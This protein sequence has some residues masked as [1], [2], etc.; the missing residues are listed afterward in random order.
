MASTLSP[1]RSLLALL[2]GQIEG[3][4]EKVLAPEAKR[5]LMSYERHL[6][7]LELDRKGDHMAAGLLL[8]AAEIASYIPSG[9]LGRGSMELT[10]LEERIERVLSAVHRLE[11]R[12]GRPKK[13][14]GVWQGGRMKPPTRPRDPEPRVEED[15]S[16]HSGDAAGGSDGE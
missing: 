2:R 11:R 15:D 6:E 5:C 13:K 10:R 14:P 12:A 1:G 4:D 9:K 16:I 8:N 3:V 7:G